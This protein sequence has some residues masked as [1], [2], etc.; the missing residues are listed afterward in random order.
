MTLPPKGRRGGRRVPHW[1]VAPCHYYRP[2]LHYTAAEVR[3]GYELDEPVAHQRAEIRA[4]RAER[5]GVL[6]RKPDPS[7][8]PSEHAGF[9]DEADDERPLEVGT[10]GSP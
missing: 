6:L 2:R 3:G 10:L 8:V 9:G 7:K 5:A 4:R 1:A